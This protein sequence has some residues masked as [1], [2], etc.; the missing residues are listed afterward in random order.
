MGERTF[1]VAEH[2][3]IVVDAVRREVATA[4]ASLEEQLAEANKRIDVLEAERAAAD[5]ARADAEEAMEELKEETERREEIASRRDS[6][7][8]IVREL[9]GGTFGDEYFTESRIQRWAEMADEAFESLLDDLA[10][11]ALATVGADP[12]KAAELA[13]KTGAERRAAVAEVVRE[14]ASVDP[15][16][17][18]RQTAAFAGGQNGGEEA[19]PK[20]GGLS[21][22][23]TKVR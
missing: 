17:L 6:R 12:E 8:A 23:L 11:T 19:K 2:E 9:A 14:R 15:A 10:D 3:A 21:A 1:T 16:N 18:K 4:T 7:V 13:T 5:K 20:S 22:L